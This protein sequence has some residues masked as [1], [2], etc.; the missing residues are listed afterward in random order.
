MKIYQGVTLGALSFPTDAEGKLVR[1][2][3]RH[4]TIEDRVVIYANATILGGETVVG[5]DSV[6]GL[7]R[8][9]DQ[10]GA[11]LHYGHDGEAPVADA[12]QK[13]RR[14]AATVKRS[15]QTRRLRQILPSSFVDGGGTSAEVF[16]GSCETDPVAQ[17]NSLP[18]YSKH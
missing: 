3:K 18:L 13:R 8:V 9:V 7:K 10:L 15:G 4:P 2:L 12:G 11:S 16:F 6:I 1:G 5:H 17:A 14:A